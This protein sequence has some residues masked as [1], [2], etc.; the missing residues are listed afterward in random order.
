MASWL[1]HLLLRLPALRPLKCTQGLP[2]LQPA[3]AQ[4][5]LHRLHQEWRGRSVR[6]ALPWLLPAPSSI[7]LQCSRR[8]RSPTVGASAGGDAAQA[9]SGGWCLRVF[10]SRSDKECHGVEDGVVT[11]YGFIQDLGPPDQADL[12]FQSEQEKQPLGTS[13]SYAAHHCAISAAEHAA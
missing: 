2:P 5:L 9:H 10:T 7:S 12:V 3:Q 11:R 6:L 8:H 4:G 1:L 13:K